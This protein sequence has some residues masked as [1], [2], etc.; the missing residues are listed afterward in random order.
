MSLERSLAQEMLALLI[1]LKEME[2]LL[3]LALTVL[4]GNHT[5]KRIARRA[6]VY[7]SYISKVENGRFNEVSY[8]ALERIL[9]AYLEVCRES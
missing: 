4:R 6:D 7:G 3:P 5:Q 9:R 8:E 1:R 2:K